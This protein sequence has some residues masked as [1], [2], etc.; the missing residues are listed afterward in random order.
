MIITLAARHK[1]PAVYNE[2]HFAAVGGLVSYGADQID[3]Y[4]RA[5]GYVDRILEGEKPADLPIQA[6]TKY[7][8]VINPKTAKAL[9]I[10]VPPSVL[11]RA[12]DIIN[13]RDV[14]YWH[15]ADIEQVQKNVRLEGKADS[16]HRLCQWAPS[17][18]PKTRQIILAL[19]LLD[20]SMRSPRQ[21]PCSLCARRFRRKTVLKAAGV[22]LQIFSRFIPVIEDIVCT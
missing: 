15:L 21:S 9:G 1:L 17:R 5:A 12:D 8:T 11:A 16:Q 18:A 3:Q 4:R 2:R 14:C 10:T 6:P 22:G 20:G 19:V 7:E 13:S